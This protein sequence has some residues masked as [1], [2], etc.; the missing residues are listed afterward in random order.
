MDPKITVAIAPNIP[1]MDSPRTP[2]SK[3]VELEGRVASST[4]PTVVVNEPEA[5]SSGDL[6]FMA[7]P[8][9]I[10]KAT[11]AP[12]LVLRDESRGV[13]LFGNSIDSV[14]SPSV[15]IRSVTGVI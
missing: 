5:N 1:P 12:A 7:R 3:S 6:A 9:I 10:R 14:E 2:A 15:F 8:A 4:F 11:K 13:P